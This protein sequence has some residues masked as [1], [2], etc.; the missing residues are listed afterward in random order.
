MSLLFRSARLSIRTVQNTTRTSQ[1]TI[2]ARV[3]VKGFQSS[4]RKMGVHNIAKLVPPFLVYAI[5]G[6]GDWDGMGWDGGGFAH[7]WGHS[8][9]EQMLT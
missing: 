1:S 5:D 7:G 6:V 3:F 2:T 9:W 8:A 4:A